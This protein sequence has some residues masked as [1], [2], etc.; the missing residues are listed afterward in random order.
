MSSTYLT[1]ENMNMLQRLL[2]EVRRLPRNIQREA[3]SARFLVH[4]FQDGTTAESD[5][6]SQLEAYGRGGDDRDAGS[7]AAQANGNA[8]GKSGF[9][10]GWLSSRS[11]PAGAPARN[12]PA[13][14]RRS[15]AQR[16]RDNDT[17]GRRRRENEVKGRN[18]MHWGRFS[19]LSHLARLSARARR[20]RGARGNPTQGVCM[21]NHHSRVFYS[22]SNGDRRLVVKTM[23]GDG[24]ILVRHEPN[25]ASGGTPSQVDIATFVAR[26]FSSPEGQALQALLVQLRKE[27]GELSEAAA[28][29]DRPAN[30][31]AVTNVEPVKPSEGEGQSPAAGKDA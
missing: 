16:L 5:L 18:Q 26:G 23:A 28:N 11:T 22:S 20:R 29:D 17:D 4:R 10:R 27:Q 3:S 19:R 1:S 24:D 6:R 30:I 12:L 15:E 9:L 7:V 25:R 8:A 14:V 2:A 21:Q 31:A 13:T